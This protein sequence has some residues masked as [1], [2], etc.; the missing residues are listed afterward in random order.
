[1]ASLAMTCKSVFENCLGGL[2][3]VDPGQLLGGP[4]VRGSTIHAGCL[5]NRITGTH[6]LKITGSWDD[7]ITGAQD[8]G[9][10][11]RRTTRSQDHKIKGHPLGRR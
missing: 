8:P 1:M 7:S 3:C 6:D 10:R 2:V 5:E 11:N 4:G 9:S